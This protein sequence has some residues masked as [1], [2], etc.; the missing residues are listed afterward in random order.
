MKLPIKQRKAKEL[1]QQYTKKNRI[2]DI[3]GLTIYSILFIA[4]AA[5]L[6]QTF[7]SIPIL[8]AS[9]FLSLAI[10][11]F[12]SGMIHWSAD[13]WGTADT[14]IFGSL[15]IHGFREHHVDAKAITHHDF[16]QTNAMSSIAAIPFQIIALLIAPTNTG[17][18]L[19]FTTLAL[20][21]LWGP[22]TNQIHKWA[23]QDTKPPLIVRIAQRTRIIL[24]KQSHDYHHTAPFECYYCI[25]TGWWNWFL[26]KIHFFR[27][28][29][30]LIT[31][32]T[33]VIPRQDD[34]GSKAA[35]MLARQ[36]GIIK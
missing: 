3:T 19:L 9:F 29:E 36:Q 26:T 28:L 8:V 14:P 34:I 1:A 12:I 5:K 35:R 31:K 15:I 16:I 13:T 2:I 6:I 30:K 18:S 4:L 24:S 10:A 33:G 27:R 20:L 11:D 21:T 17:T 23:H 7:T 25:T 32:L 22:L